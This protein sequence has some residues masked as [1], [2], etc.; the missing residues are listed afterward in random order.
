MRVISSRKFKEASKKC[1]DCAKQFTLLDEDLKKMVFDNLNQVKDCFP[2]V[3]LLKNSRA[4]FNVHG[5]KYRVVV[6][7]NFKMKICY[8][9]F[10]GTHAE[11][12]K[13]DA[14]TI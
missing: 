12:D 2:Y 8:V 11:Y 7:F 9:R 1:P 5:N 13:I 3:S 4:V 6:R 14:N 10:I